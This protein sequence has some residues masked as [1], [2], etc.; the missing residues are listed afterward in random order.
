MTGAEWATAVRA[1]ADLTPS[2]QATLEQAAQALDRARAAQAEL[3]EH[4]VLIDGLHGLKANP[5]ATLKRDAIQ[6]Y[7]RLSKALGLETRAEAPDTLEH[8]GGLL[9]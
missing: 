2:Q 3:E 5:A 8:S 6:E 1:E 4:G 7:L 9:D